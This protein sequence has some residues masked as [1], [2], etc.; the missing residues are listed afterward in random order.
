MEA[1]KRYPKYQ[2]RA[3]AQEWARRSHV[4]QQIKRNAIGPD[5]ETLRKR[6]Q[7]DTKGTILREGCTYTATGETIWQVR[8]SIVG[9][10]DQLDLVANGETIRTSG[11]R[12]LP[13]RFRP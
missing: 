5:P 12:R 1:L 10:V 13:R 2:R 9:R 8:R 11:P 3:I 7:F 4:A 6:E